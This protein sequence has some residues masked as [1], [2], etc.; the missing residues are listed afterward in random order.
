MLGVGQVELRRY[1]L[2]HPQPTIS[3]A[4]WRRN[5]QGT[6]VQG[7]SKTVLSWTVLTLSSWAMSVRGLIKPFKDPTTTAL[8][9]LLRPIS[10]LQSRTVIPKDKETTNATHN[11]LKSSICTHLEYPRQVD[12]PTLILRSNPISRVTN[13]TIVS[14]SPTSNSI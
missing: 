11:I 12:L 5:L 9:G 10:T 13:T 3:T 4:T 8:S 14:G 2:G 6:S 1:I 7:Q